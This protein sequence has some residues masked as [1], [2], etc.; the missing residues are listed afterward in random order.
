LEL[1]ATMPSF[2]VDE[3]SKRYEG[4]LGSS[5]RRQVDAVET[6]IT[7][8][9][10]VITRRNWSRNGKPWKPDSGFIPNAGF[11]AELKP[12]FSPDCPTQLELRDANQHAETCCWLTDSVLHRMRASYSG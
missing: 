4:R 5:K 7:V 12:L 3:I 9:G 10:T 2:V 6:E 8:N 1:V 11:D